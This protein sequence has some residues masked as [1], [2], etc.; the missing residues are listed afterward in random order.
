MTQYDPIP[1]GYRGVLDNGAVLEVVD[2]DW[3]RK[4]HL[5]ADV[6]VKTGA[7]E[8]LGSGKLQLSSTQDRYRLAQE[9]AS[10]NG[11]NPTDWANELL[12]L[13]TVLDQERRD[14]AE[15][16]NPIDLSQFDEP[17]PVQDA[18][19]N[20]LPAKM[21][22][23]LY[24]DS[25]QGK[26]TVVNG[27]AISM[28]MGWGFLEHS[29]VPGAVVLLDWE[30]TRDITLGRL[31]RIARGMG[32]T[33]PPAIFYQSMTDPLGVHLDDITEWCHNIQPGL[34]VVDSMGPA[35]GGD[36]NDHEK[37][38]ALMNQIRKLRMTTWVVDHQ[39]KPIGNQSYASKREF[40]SGYKR[41]LTRSSLQLEMASNE[42]GKA[43]LVLRQQK[44]NFGPKS[45]PIGFH[46]LYQG[47][48]IKFEIADIWLPNSRTSKLW[49]LT[50]K[51]SSTCVKLPGPPKSKS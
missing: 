5:Y 32:L 12:A 41:H 34:V 39:S 24:G 27:L 22:S 16:F 21:T 6:I 45:D 13:W 40:G 3:T 18:W 35:C 10:H 43:S 30:L 19:Q 33:N 46:I 23:T 36:P 9:L 28:M 15:R 8:P 44:N 37:S 50:R 20:L 11:S 7:D 38:I 49:P 26:S 31:Y 2:L 47:D 51:L 42:P 4:G 25:G 48:S 29:T 17:E 1:R 14:N